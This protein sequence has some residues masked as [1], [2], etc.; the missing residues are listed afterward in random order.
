MVDVDTN[1]HL[2]IAV[3]PMSLLVS[4]HLTLIQLY[5]ILFPALVLIP[6]ILENSLSLNPGIWDWMSSYNSMAFRMRGVFGVI[7]SII[8]Y[9]APKMLHT[10]LSITLIMLSICHMGNPFASTTI[11]ADG[12]RIF[13]INI[14]WRSGWFLL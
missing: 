6:F 2:M 3:L 11:Y 12:L 7:D 8:S 5:L 1:T 10:I 4:P 13:F 14:L 9:F